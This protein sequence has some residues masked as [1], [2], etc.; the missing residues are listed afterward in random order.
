MGVAGETVEELDATCKLGSGE[1]ATEICAGTSELGT[2]LSGKPGD[3]ET[4]ISKRAGLRC[5]PDVG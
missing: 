3:E 1:P 2:T 4:A 5:E